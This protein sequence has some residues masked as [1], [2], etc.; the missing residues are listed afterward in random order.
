MT[1]KTSFSQ[2]FNPLPI[3]VFLVD[4]AG[5]VVA[6]NEM[7]IKDFNLRGK[8]NLT[9]KTFLKTVITINGES[10]KKSN[11]AFYRVLKNK[12]IVESQEIVV[13]NRTRKRIFLVSAGPIME[14]DKITDVIMTFKNVTSELNQQ[15]LQKMFIKMV[16][17]ELK[18]PLG[19]I[20][21]YTYYLNKY[22][23][24]NVTSVGDNIG[25]INTQIKMIAQMLN[26]VSD[27]TRYSL[28]SF[29]IN[30]KNIDIKSL[31]AAVA[32]ELKTSFP[33]RQLVYQDKIKDKKLLL[34]VDAV[35]IRQAI[36]NLVS[37]AFKYSDETDPVMLTLSKNKNILQIEVQDFG[38]GIKKNEIDKI[39]EPYYRVSS[40]DIR[41]VSGL[42][43]GLALV[44]TI[45]DRHD[46]SIKVK[47]VLMKGST[48]TLCLPLTNLK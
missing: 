45:L 3:A 13:L 2:Y 18:Q 46:G 31:T 16:S 23:K 12:K 40:H 10:F 19:L 36:T 1:I 44:K 43:L 27:A 38:V 33:H 39:F 34:S 7:A 8:K 29:T 17:H 37:N 5:A 30:K 11:F 24:R 32:N 9:L 47:S 15:Y 26:D 28:K 48:F 4:K 6:V 14:G 25:K 41:K 42:G 21:A 22:F 20:K 35:R